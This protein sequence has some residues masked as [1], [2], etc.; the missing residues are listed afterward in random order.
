MTSSWCCKKAK[1]RRS[2]GYDLRKCGQWWRRRM[3]REYSSRP[4]AHHGGWVAPKVGSEVVGKEATGEELVEVTPQEWDCRGSQRN[5]YGLQRLWTYQLLWLMS[6]VTV[7]QLDRIPPSEWI[8]QRRLKDGV[9]WIKKESTIRGGARTGVCKLQSATHVSSD[10]YEDIEYETTQGF[11]VPRRTIAGITRSEV[12]SRSHSHCQARSASVCVLAMKEGSQ[13]VQSTSHHISRSSCW[14]C[15]SLL[16]EESLSHF[17]QAKNSYKLT[18]SYRY[19]AV[20][21]L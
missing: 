7:F 17:L 21:V 8:P 15:R 5:Q 9:K 1:E 10:G 14:S 12:L 2:I 11:I 18:E 6:L 4:H 19:S 13:M 3:Q 16:F 20:D